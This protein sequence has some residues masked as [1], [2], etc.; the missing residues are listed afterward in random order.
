MSDEEH[1][2]EAVLSRDGRKPGLEQ[3]TWG[4]IESTERRTL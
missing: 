1:L 3:A 2:G 4:T